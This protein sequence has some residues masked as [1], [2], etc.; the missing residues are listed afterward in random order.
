MAN[1]PIGTDTLSE[2]YQRLF[3]GKS[4][5]GILRM[6]MIGRYLLFVPMLIPLFAAVNVMAA[7][8]Y[9][10]FDQL[11]YTGSEAFGDISRMVEAD[12]NN[13]IDDDGDGLID[14]ADIEDCA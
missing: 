10:D 12:C 2:G 14:A 1:Y 13:G 8:G 9:E 11:R 5:R 6:N 4:G 3:K 7:T